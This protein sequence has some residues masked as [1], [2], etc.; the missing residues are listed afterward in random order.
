MHHIV[1]RTCILFFF[2]SGDSRSVKTVCTNMFTN[3]ASCVNLQISR[4]IIKK[5][6]FVDM[7]RH[8]TYMYSTSQRRCPLT[9]RS[10]LARA[11]IVNI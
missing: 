8:K 7:Y 6:I 4:V 11:L 10:E 2:K 9:R 5:S 1:K 3:M